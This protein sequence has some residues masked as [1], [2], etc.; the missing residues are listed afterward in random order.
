MNAPAQPS[1]PTASLPHDDTPDFDSDVLD[2][3][4]EEFVER[5]RKGEAPAI[6]EYEAR[7]PQWASRIR[8]LFPSI[9]MME[10]LKRRLQT[11]RSGD[12][13][14]SGSSPV[15]PERF[16]E[17]RV[18]REL[19]RG[20]MGIVY[21]AVQES[22]NRH[23]ALKVI[24][25]HNAQDAK[26]MAR[27]RRESQAV[28]SLHHT[29][30]VP[31]FGV[32]EHDGLPFYVMQFIQGDGLDRRLSKWRL[33]GAPPAPE[34][35]RLV[36]TL[37]AQAADALH[38]AH[39]QGVLHRDIKPANILVDEHESAWITDFGLVKL[40]GRDDL[41]TSGDVIGTLRYLAPESL[42]G[43]SD[44]RSDVYSLGLTLYE[45]LTLQPPYGDVGPS[46]LL[47]CVTDE[48]PTRPRKLD[49]SIPT[50]LETIVLK[51]TARE[52]QH[53]YATAGEMA[54]D[55]RA[56]LED[57][58]IR[59]RRA[60]GPERL[61]RWC[62]RNKMVATLAATAAFSML[63]AASAGWLAF[64]SE[65]RK[66]DEAEKATKLAQD[67][68]Q[69]ADDNVALSLAAFEQLFETLAARGDF[70]PGR[71][72][73]GPHGPNRRQPPPG[74]NGRPEGNDSRP[75]RGDML[76]LDPG[77]HRPPD[78]GPGPPSDPP[79]REPNGLPEND[80]ILIDNILSFYD[81][82]AEKN[83]TNSKLQEEAARANRR[84]AALYQWL[85]RDQ[86]A[87][88]TYNKA[89]RR[90]EELATRFPDDPF[91][92]FELART[93]A[94]DDAWPASPAVSSNE[95]ERL[96]KALTIVDNLAA[97]MPDEPKY[98]MAQARWLNRLGS[99][100][101]RLKRTPEAEASLRESIQ[102]DQRLAERNPMMLMYRIGM[103]GTQNAL[104]DFLARHDRGEEA[105]KLLDSVAA[106][107]SSLTTSE[108]YSVERD[109][110]PFADRFDGLARSAS[111]LGQTN[112]AR[113]LSKLAR[114][115]DDQGP[116][117]GRR[118]GRGGPG[119]GPPGQGDDRPGRDR[120]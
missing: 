29:N 106:D 100:L 45:L 24:P 67:A 33:E 47:R 34:H 41:T 42:R 64:A 104:I 65:N 81:H 23:V 73:D 19:G 56:F 52:A 68:T 74:P 91:Y 7:Y 103:A 10:T 112:Q 90:Y 25:R 87:E 75:R 110:R 69:R 11:A 14:A 49:G 22:L 50:D 58:P 9:A 80:V 18:V 37:G 105:V 71:A 95:E 16:G 93:Y 77:G 53:R 116:P 89:A 28:A 108:A 70:R 39:D 85:G 96:R 120:N 30:I 13:G 83:E 84:V 114:G 107:L 115:L 118:P 63:L 27:F 20:G 66:R 48:Q 61:A 97:E 76:G 5:S 86:E 35:W 59:A 12:H 99:T 101:D 6:A 55:L 92:R 102:I 82:F 78:H 8:E 36:A 88:D 46:E 1:F 43:E 2:R 17:F 51:A 62:R 4:A 109:G 40:V 94:M 98:R 119:L 21:E 111:A 26:R 15:L 117:R 32:G 72:G 3:L 113:E 38:Y 79:P 44:Q 57:R 60:S 31:L 54:A